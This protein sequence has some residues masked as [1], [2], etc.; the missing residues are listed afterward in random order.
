MADEIKSD[1]PWVPIAIGGIALVV[2]FKFLQRQLLVLKEDIIRDFYLIVDSSFV[3]LILF[4]FL[5][6]FV[7]CVFY[8]VFCWVKRSRKEKREME[9]KVREEW[10]FVNKFLRENLKHFNY[11][12]LK[13]RLDE[14][15]GMSFLKEYEGLDSKIEEARRTLVEIKH[16]DELIEII[17]EKSLAKREVEEL[18][19][20]VEE[21]RRSDVQKKNSLKYELEMDENKVFNKANLNEEEVEILLEEGYRQV[22]EYCVFQKKI[23]TVLIR[24]TLNHSVAHTFLVWSVRQLLESYFEVE[25]IVEHETREPDLTFRVKGKL[26]AIEIET[27]TLLRKKDQLEKKI[28]DLNGKYKNRWLI[29]VSK[30]E[31]VN[32]YSSFGL[33][34]QRK[35]VCEKLEKMAGI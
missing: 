17:N 26:F 2:I 9:K 31:L 3:H 12:N 1:D 35:W 4:F 29:V 27:G 24:P 21:L 8:V 14:V 5:G 11:D 23:I 13:S 6:I 22:N 18:E 30:R 33:C 20:R 32:K 10:I 7:S 16:S 28:K 19:L 15:E 25:K 34:T